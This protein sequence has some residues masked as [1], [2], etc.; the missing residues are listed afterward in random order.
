MLRGLITFVCY[1]RH[2]A[3]L[4]PIPSRFRFFWHSRGCEVTKPKDLGFRA[5]VRPSFTKISF[6]LDSG[7][8]PPLAVVPER[9]GSAE[10]Y[11]RRGREYSCNSPPS[12]VL[13]ASTSPTTHFTRTDSFASPIGIFTA[14]D[15]ARLGL[16][17][18]FIFAV[19]A[20]QHHAL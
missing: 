3:Q 16:N 18:I 19:S 5:S 11:P 7:P 12:E 9:L 10:T 14:S 1:H 8:L 20:G 13:R 15:V 4:F 2:R 17:L 6:L